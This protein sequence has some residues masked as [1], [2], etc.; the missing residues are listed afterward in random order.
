MK[1]RA[2]GSAYGGRPEIRE[3]FRAERYQ[4][5]F[6]TSSSPLFRL[7]GGNPLGLSGSVPHHLDS[8][9]RVQLSL[10]RSADPPDKLLRPHSHVHSQKSQPTGTVGPLCRDAPHRAIN[11]IRPNSESPNQL[12]PPRPVAPLPKIAA[13][14]DCRPTCRDAPHRAINRIR[15]NSKSPNQLRRPRQPCHRAE[16]RSRLG[17]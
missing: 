1:E 3:S 5:D 17:L 6:Q 10:C 8:G 16:R 2:A 13:D 15:P 4:A 9:S 7:K 14:R 11:R 12:H